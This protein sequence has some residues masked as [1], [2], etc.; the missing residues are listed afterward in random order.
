MLTMTNDNDIAS[1]FKVTICILFLFGRTAKTPYLVQ[2]Y[3]EHRVY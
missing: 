2:P 3:F 1:K